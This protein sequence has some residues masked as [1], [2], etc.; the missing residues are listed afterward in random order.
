MNNLLYNNTHQNGKNAQKCS[1][2]I[3][4]VYGDICNLLKYKA[5]SFMRICTAPVM[6]TVR[7]LKFS[8]LFIFTVAK[9]RCPGIF[10]YFT[11]FS[12]HDQCTGLAE[13]PL[14]FSDCTMA[15]G[16]GVML[17]VAA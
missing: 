11:L 9:Y 2:C 5:M 14:G 16:R 6:S 4:F 7:D 1:F 15:S 10:I 13:N 8:V 17:N 12:I 3:H